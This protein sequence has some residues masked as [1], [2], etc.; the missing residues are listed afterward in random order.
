MM[1]KPTIQLLLSGFLGLGWCCHAEQKLFAVPDFQELP[2][3]FKVLSEKTADGVRVTEFYMSGAPFNGAPTRLYAFY[4][5]PE[6]PGPYPGVVQL[7][8]A[9]LGVLKPEAA[10]FYAKNG[11]A[12]ISIDWCG[13]EKE[14]HVPRKPPYSE[15]AAAGNL[16]SPLLNPPT[17]AVAN[18]QPWKI[19]LPEHSGITNGVKFVRRALMFL[20]SRPEVDSGKL[21]LSGMSAGAH[22]SLLVIGQEPE[23]RAAAVKY[24]CAFIRDLPGFFGGYFGPVAMTAKED[25]DAWLAVLDPKHYITGYRASVLLLSGTDDIF[26]WMPVV[27]YTYRA[28]PTSKRLLM[29]PNDNHTQVENEVLPLRYFNAILGTAA[30]F[31]AIT[32]RPARPEGDNVRLTMN[33]T[34]PSTLTTVAYVFKTMPANAFGFA[35]GWTVKPATKNAA[36]W[37]LMVPAP[38][39][40]EQMVA[41]GIVEDE[42]G[43]KTTSDTVEFPEYPAWRG[44]QPAPRSSAGRA[45]E[46]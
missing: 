4:A 42:T 6:K 23:L 18:N 26:F 2:P 24:G 34:A 19:V 10:I 40:G 3:N 15:F 13:P 31:P 7:H 16:A 28:I 27:L 20:R 36:A 38:K 8:G 17:G 37:E 14:R 11:F 35:G 25:Q 43:A 46:K 41:Y 22:V 32:V 44:G 33:I 39:P 45:A 29:L 1:R 5:C 12:C 30:A 21:C 9:G